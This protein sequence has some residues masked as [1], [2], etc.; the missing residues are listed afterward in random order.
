MKNFAKHIR[1][2]ASMLLALVM[3]VAGFAVPAY[4][5]SDW[6]LLEIRL[7]WTDTDGNTQEAMALP[8]AWS[9]DQSFWAQVTADAPLSALTINI[10][11]PD[12]AYTYD[13]A[14]GSTLLEV[15][16]A[17]EEMDVTNTIVINAYDGENLVDTFNLYIS[18]MIEMPEEPTPE[19]TE[20]PTPEPT[21]EPTPEPTE[22]PTP[23]PTEEPT[24]EPTEEPTP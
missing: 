17:G 18:T 23:E 10:S 13:P 15:V 11:H 8:V 7:S 14:D 12:H 19:P 3:L 2:A 20:E 6:D 9:E 24:P 5:G 21:E 1:R 16:D 22:E 4:A